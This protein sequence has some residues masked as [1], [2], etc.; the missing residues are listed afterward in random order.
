[1][2]QPELS[3]SDTG[4]PA[5]LLI[6]Q[7]T[8][9]H[10][11]SAADVLGSA[12]QG[13]SAAPSGTHLENLAESCR[14]WLEIL[15]ETSEAELPATLRTAIT[16]Q[17]NHLLWLIE[18]AE[19]FGTASVSRETNRVIGSL[20]QATT[21]LTGTDVQTGGRWKRAFL[22]IVG[23]S[24]VF[25]AGATQLQSALE[26]GSGMVKEIVQVVDDVATSAE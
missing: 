12:L 22:G 19:L 23:A 14:S 9:D 21:I 4:R 16:A 20:T 6:S 5:S 8:L 24:I 3:W 7:E 25:S 1:M 13:T 11:A 18:H 26:A 15:A 2:V 10:L 17:I